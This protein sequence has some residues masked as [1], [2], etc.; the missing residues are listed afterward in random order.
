[1]IKNIFITKRQHDLETPIERKSIIDSLG[2]TWLEET[3]VSDD[4]E[5]VDNFDLFHEAMKRHDYFGLDTENSSLNQFYAIPLLLQIAIPDENTS[6]VIDQT[7]MPFDY[8]N[9]YKDKLFIGH[10]IQYDY[11]IIKWHMGLELRNLEDIMV[12]EQIL[13]RGSGRL[14]NLQ[15]VYERRTGK[16]LP[17]EKSTRNDFLSMRKNAVFKRKHIIYSGFDPQ[18][19]LEIKPIQDKLITQYKLERRVW[20]IAMPL[21]PILGDTNIEGRTLNKTKWKAN[22]EKNKKERFRLEQQ[23]DAIIAEFAKDEVKLRGGIWTS[24]SRTRKKAEIIQVGLFGNDNV[25]TNDTV[26]NVSYNST[27][28]LAKLFKI[29]G[30]PL[31]LK[32]DKTAE[33]HWDEEPK[34]KVSFD[35][36]TLEQYKIEYP[37]SRMKEFITILIDFKEIVKEIDAFGEIF[38]NE[39]VK[40]G[41]SGKKHKRG[42]YQPLTNKIHTIYKQEFTDN[43]RL[44][45]GG[46]KK[47]KG[48]L[49][50]G[51]DN[52]QNWPKKSEFRECITLTQQEIDEGWEISTSDLSAA[53]LVILAS[54]SQDKALMEH[55]RGDLHSYLATHSYSKT[56]EYIVNSMSENRAYDELY[57]LLKVNRIQK[58]WKIYDEANPNGR[59]ATKEE[60][61]K[62]TKR[63]VEE[64]FSIKSIK[65]N[66]KQ[67]VDIRD[68]YKNVTYGVTYGAAEHKI[69]KTLNIAPYYAKLVMEG[70]NDAIPQAMAYLKTQAKNAVKNGY[71]I[72]NDRTNSRHWFKSWLEADIYGR[73][74]SSG[75]KAAIERFTMNAVCSGTQ[76]DMAKEATVAVE[77]WKRDSNIDLKWLMFVHDEWVYK[78]KGGNDVRLQ[79]EKIIADTCN[80]YLNNIS[81]EV[82]GHTKLF[83]Y[84]G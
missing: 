31:P 37:D 79:V 84:K 64:A 80:L 35:S 71:V 5:V 9:E 10:N 12:K 55:C 68:P 8:L 32:E 44:A 69:A 19:G 83:W 23:M 22:L 67:H 70:I 74:L 24:A 48:D 21:I 33:R 51:F 25:T 3:P 20:D 59:K 76:A 11:R 16:K 73:K 65:I 54:K 58:A 53:E 1:M 60:E 39:Y 63:R 77:K 29:L 30:E 45:S 2:K 38:I 36:P 7:C 26:K 14:N 62:E 28:Q 61:I 52:S 75:E 72:F 4:I 40:D 49:G 46:E 66:K 56:I 42:Y 34:M 82:A 78:H 81:M 17:E 57:E 43:G 6:F 15:A 27:T 47:S 41:K 50:I 18:T 13:G